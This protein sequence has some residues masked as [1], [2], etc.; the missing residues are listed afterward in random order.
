MRTLGPLLLDWCNVDEPGISFHNIY[1]ATLGR[2]SSAVRQAP[3]LA[4]QP[5]IGIRN[6]VM[7]I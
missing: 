5:T 6:V 3:A 7:A 1:Y 2:H 4:P